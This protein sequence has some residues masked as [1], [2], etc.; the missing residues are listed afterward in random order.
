M[1][2]VLIVDDDPI[3]CS[4]LQKLIQW[5]EYGYNAGSFAHNGL[6]A[7]ACMEKDHYD[8]IIT[9]IRMPKLD[10]IGLIKEMKQKGHHAKVI[11]LSGYSDFE[12]AQTALEFGARKYL[13]KPVNALKLI[14]S[15]SEI[16]KEITEEI[17]QAHVIKESKMIMTEKIAMDLLTARE[18]YSAIYERAKSIGIAL[19]RMTFQACAIEKYAYEK[20]GAE[21]QRDQAAVK[22][23]VEEAIAPYAACFMIDASDSRLAV[24][25]CMDEKW[26]YP[27]K[28][29]LGEIAERVK[30]RAGI[31]VNIAVGNEITDYKLVHVS[32]RHASMGLDSRLFNSQQHLLF[33]DQDPENNV[34]QTIIAYI[35]D[36][37]C[38]KLSL[39]DIAQLYFYNP[40]YLGRN[41]KKHTGSSFNDFLT[42]CKINRATRLLEEKR[43]KISEISESVGYTDYDSFVQ[44]FKFR[45][46]C[47]P[48]EYRAGSIK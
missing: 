34:M 20:K 31:A 48:S 32:M 33:F 12:Y 13:L 16:N 27:F 9:D 38:E 42:E 5:Q 35:Q 29:I 22:K 30:V 37:C 10:G 39:R 36:H 18:D 17:N 14:E 25:A 3:I 7:L 15:I 47:T 45:K 1:Y 4:G 21:A 11:I 23:A 28:D 26:A 2:Q 41:F 19:E 24:L 6:E 40:A 44:A 8:L 46:G 43:L